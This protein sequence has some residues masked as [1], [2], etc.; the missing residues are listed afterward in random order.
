MTLGV[1]PCL[2][3]KDELCGELYTVLVS[4]SLLN[5]CY[6]RSSHISSRVNV[7]LRETGKLQRSLSSGCREQVRLLMT[8]D[9]PVPTSIIQD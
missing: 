5:C 3:S 2:F 4:A 9:V 6:V 1:V 8:A 7:E